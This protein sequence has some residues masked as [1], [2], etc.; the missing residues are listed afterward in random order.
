MNAR[1][2]VT[3]MIATVALAAA[4]PAATVYTTHAGF[5]AATSA[6]GVDGFDGLSITGETRSPLAR[7]AGSYSYVAAAS[8]DFW[9]AGSGA[10]PWLATSTAV[11]PIV[12]TGF[13]DDV[14]GVGGLFFASDI[15]GAYMAGDVTVTLVDESGSTSWTVASATT[16]SFVG[17]VSEGAITSLTVSAAQGATLTFTTVDDLTLALAATVTSAVPEP[18][19][20]AMMLLGFGMVAATGRHRRR[21]TRATRA[22]CA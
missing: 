7:T 8:N 6:A 1:L 11:D 12:F 20:W 10:D 9:G 14:R 17:F 4:A 21:A 15:V 19:T 3:A 5:A 22:I 16:G 2:F 18:A 13:T